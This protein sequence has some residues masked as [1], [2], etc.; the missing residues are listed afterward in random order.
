[1]STTVQQIFEKSMA[2]YDEISTNGTIDPTKTADYKART[3]YIVDMLQKELVLVSDLYKWH[4]FAYTSDNTNPWVITDLPSDVKS[5]TKVIVSKDYCNYIPYTNY[6][7]EKN[8]STTSIYI[9]YPFDA[10][11]RVQYRP[12]PTTITAITDTLQVDDFTANVIVYGLTRWFAASESNEV[13]ERICREQYLSQ[14][15]ELKQGQPASIEPI[16][17]VYRW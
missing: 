4:E 6:K 14:K 16:V 3:P 17:D 2:L 13:V 5:I 11:V 15:S 7:L 12:I 9:D 10:T 8:G 1:M